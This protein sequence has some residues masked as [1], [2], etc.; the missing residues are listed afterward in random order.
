MN[1]KKICFIACV[2]D[3]DFFN[4]CLLY[5]D[6][7]Y[8]PDGFEIDVLSIEEAKSMTS[9]YNEGMN[10]SDAK[11]KIYLHQDIVKKIFKKR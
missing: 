1:E 8:V 10:A 9:G 3:I 2:N 5:I 6:R 7:L 4:E 11:Y